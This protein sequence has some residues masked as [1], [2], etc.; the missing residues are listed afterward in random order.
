[1]PPERSAW[2]YAKL[3]AGG[4]LAVA[5]VMWLRVEMCRD[6]GLDPLPCVFL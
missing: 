3:V 2:F 1:M 6:L 5:F 4:F